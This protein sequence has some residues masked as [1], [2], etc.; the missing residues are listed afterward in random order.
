MSGFET[1]RGRSEL[2]ELAGEV[3]HDLAELVRKELQLA[4]VEARAEASRGARLG[5][6]AGAAL[7][8]GALAGILLALAAAMALGVVLP[9]WAAFLVVAGACAA[10]AAGLAL[11]VVPR[12][13]KVHVVPPETAASVK[14]S[15]Q[16]IRTRVRG[17]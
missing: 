15:L 11:V 8:A 12:A 10:P 14:E 2:G 16:W 7:A 13:S 1:A 4:M 17:S 6:G 3:V 9:L 5:I